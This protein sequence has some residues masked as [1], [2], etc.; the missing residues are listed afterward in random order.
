MKRV[1]LGYKGG[2]PLEQETL[3]QIQAAYEEDMLEALFALWGLNP[4]KKYLIRESS[5]THEGWV[6]MPVEIEIK[7]SEVNNV[8]TPIKREKPQ[9]VRLQYKSRGNT[10]TKFK[11]VD[12]RE[13]NGTLQYAEG[14]EKKVYEEFVGVFKEGGIHDPSDK[15]EFIP[16]LSI[17]ELES[18]IN[19]VENNL[20]AQIN[21]VEGEL[22]SEIDQIKESYLPRDGSKSMTG[23]L[24]LGGVTNDLIFNKADNNNIDYI[25]YHDG[26][27][28]GI[29][30]QPNPGVFDFVADKA[31]GQKGNAWIR[32]GG[33]IT[34][35]IG[36]GVDR[37][38]KSLEIDANNE[39]LKF[40]NLA[41]ND[42][43]IPLVIDADGNVGKNPAGIGNN[44]TAS[45]SPGMVMMWSGNPTNVPSGWVLCDG[46]TNING[47]RI[48]DLRG[49]FVVGY[50][51]NSST[52]P[53]N[54]LNKNTDNYGRIH[55]TG[56]VRDVRLTTNEIPAH[57]HKM[58]LNSGAFFA[59][60]T[61]NPGGSGEGHR[62]T[63]DEGLDNNAYTDNN[64][65]GGQSHENRPP[66]YV[67]AYIVYVGDFNQTPI[68]RI[69]FGDNTT[70]QKGKTLAEGETLKVSLKGTSSSDPDGGTINTYFWERRFRRGSW[71]TMGNNTT[72]VVEYTIPANNYGIHSFRLN[73]VVDNEGGESTFSNTIEYAI[74]QEVTSELTLSSYQINFTKPNQSKFLQLTSNT[75]W[76]IEEITA[77]GSLIEV[78]PSSGNGNVNRLEFRSSRLIPRGV[79]IGRLKASTLDGTIERILNYEIDYDDTDIIINPPPCFDLESDVL[80][81]SGQSKKLKNIVVG[82]ELRIY[83]FAQPL[84]SLNNEF[85]SLSDLMKG[86]T[87]EGSKVVEFGTQTVDEYRKITL[88]SGEIINVTAS[89]P[90]LASKD[91]EEVAW[92]LPDDLRGGNFIVNKDGELVEIGS[93]RTVRESLEIGILQLEEGDNYFIND[94]MVHNANIIRT[95]ARTSE[96]IKSSVI[97]QDVIVDQ[98]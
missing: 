51:E 9:L 63:M 76:K 38:S 45:F 67:L 87:K 7:G 68:A 31:K 54:N 70:A 26:S 75:D 24:N 27:N 30:D 65:G 81:A 36:I 77:L 78:T 17:L 85:V 22:E 21:Q 43:Q 8:A 41:D 49:R 59:T 32:S 58:Q 19:Q 53:T 79:F 25:S 20:E 40:T 92:L 14:S 16:L 4:L 82:D 48:P 10:H 39:T 2:F 62:R 72:G 42:S 29:E 94:V 56:G 57:N 37:T 91:K 6:I 5:D 3:M 44:N 50:N 1:V 60:K 23:D 28:S 96:S 35:K 71:I 84:S 97:G 55:N 47:I 15:D 83:N 11:L 88:V 93:K 90:I 46:G 18:K 13:A 66:Y 86:A 74:L 95:I 34:D 80:M 61:R 73:K 89:H 33:L 52:T 64:A 69:T 98:K 12:K